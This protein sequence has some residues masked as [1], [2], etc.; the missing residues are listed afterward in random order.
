MRASRSAASP[1]VSSDFPNE[2]AAKIAVHTVKA[3]LDAQDQHIRVIFNV[4][5]DIDLHIYSH[6]LEDA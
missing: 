5:K 6:L 2:L 4:F 3:F 1:L